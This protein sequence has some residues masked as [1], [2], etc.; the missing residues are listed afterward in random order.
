MQ[1]CGW[2]CCILLML[3]LLFSYYS[4]S[5]ARPFQQHVWQMWQDVF[6]KQT[7]V[8]NNKWKFQRNDCVETGEGEKAGVGVWRA[9]ESDGSTG[10]GTVD[11]WRQEA[12][13][14][15][16][17]D[18][19]SL[20]HVWGSLQKHLSLSLSLSRY[21]NEIMCSLYTNLLRREISL[22]L[23]KHPYN[24]TAIDICLR[25][26]LQTC[27]LFVITDSQSYIQSDTTVLCMYVVLIFISIM[28]SCQRV[29]SL[30]LSCSATALTDIRD[31]TE[32]SCSNCH[33]HWLIDW[34]KD[35]HPTYWHEI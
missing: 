17:W 15:A 18:A 22:C 23:R 11:S 6:S 32:C 3:L 1:D 9:H 5:I 19:W 31:G 29:H 24:P 35:L 4:Y 33:G 16:R 30:S 7:S 28:Y 27:I 26:T 14:T 2:V 25:N 10:E 13:Q 34:L 12:Q 21:F 8:G 20:Q